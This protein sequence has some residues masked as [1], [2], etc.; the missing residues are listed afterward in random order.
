[1]NPNLCRLVLRPRGPLEVFDLAVA[2]ARARWRPLLSMAGLMLGWVWLLCLPLCWLV[3]G[4]PWLLLIPVVLSPLLQ[5]PFTLLGGRLLFADEASAR[6]VLRDLV[7]RR[8]GLAWSVALCAV[9]GLGVLMTCG[10]LLPVVGPTLLYLPETA[11]LERVPMRRGVSRSVRLAGGH[12]GTA[13]TGAAAWWVLTAWGAGVGEA[14]GQA[15]VAFV[16]QLGEPFGSAL[17]GDVTPW[18]LGGMLLAQPAHALFRLLLYVDVRTRVEGW[19]L[20]VGLR[21]AGLAR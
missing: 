12:A 1:M 10:V 15:L 7:S 14:T 13:L 19:D 20:Q 5:A 4:A 2:L 6:G 17:R 8:V 16:F 9:G 18:M 3:E 11:L 21:A